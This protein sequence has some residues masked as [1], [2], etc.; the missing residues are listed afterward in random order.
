MPLRKPDLTGSAERL[1]LLVGMGTF[2]TPLF[3]AWYA[4]RYPQGDAAAQMRYERS[5]GH[6]PHAD[7]SDFHFD[8]RG[9]SYLPRDLHPLFSSSRVQGDVGVDVREYGLYADKMLRSDPTPD[10]R[11]KSFGL[12][13]GADLLSRRN[14]V[15][16]HTLRVSFSHF[17]MD[18]TL[19]LRD[20]LTLDEYSQVENRFGIDAT[21]RLPVF[22]QTVDAALNAHL[23]DLSEGLPGSVRPFFFQGSAA[24][25]LPLDA[26][27][28]LEAGAALILFRGSDHASQLRL[29][30]TLLLRHALDADWSLFCGWVPEVR[31]RTLE[32]F[33]ALNPYLML[34]S[35]VRHTDLPWRFTLG[36]E[37]DD[38]GHSSARVALEYLSSTSWPR[39]SL[40]PDPVRQQWELRYDGRA[41]IIQ[42]HA[43]LAHHVGTDT[44]LQLGLDLR[45]STMSGHQGRVPYLPDY[46]ARVLLTHDF[47]FALQLRSTL[48]LVGE[49][50]ADG[51]ALPAWLLLGLELEYRVF[52]NVGVFLR[53]DNLL[54]QDRQLWPGYR[55]RPFFMMGGVTAHI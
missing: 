45:T 39:F 27:T 29:Y 1:R 14:A 7:Y 34:S 21:T 51:G 17:T 41:S 9:G 2:S 37:Y 43:D 55:E 48:Q 8:L 25:A 22:G 42:M 15:A 13:M 4:D 5:N 38:R 31:E 6:V 49:Q 12:R 47:P 28:R 33:L 50:E 52:T 19:G 23:H 30:P 18:E 53:F 24:T 44:R 36:T 16:E 54:D 20:S 40:L 3:Q 11:R 26:A 10:F 46:E 35:A 32:Q